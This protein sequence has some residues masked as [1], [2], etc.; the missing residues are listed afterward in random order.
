MVT[1]T[2]NSW[3]SMYP[4]SSIGGYT[5]DVWEALDFQLAPSSSSSLSYWLPVL[6]W[7]SAKSYIRRVCIKHVLSLNKYAVRE[8]TVLQR[9]KCHWLDSIRCVKVWTLNLPRKRGETLSGRVISYVGLS[10]FWAWISMHARERTVLQRRK[11]HWLDSR[12]VKVWTLNLRK[13]GG[14]LPGRVILLRIEHVLSL[15]KYACTRTHSFTEEKV[16]LTW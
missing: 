12:C 11:C 4:S 2:Q 15:S 6:V 14:I 13:H 5:F 9:R 8:S 3:I 7:V 10:M 16:S 1:D